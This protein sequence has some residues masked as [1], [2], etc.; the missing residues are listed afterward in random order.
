MAIFCVSFAPDSFSKTQVIQIDCPDV[1]EVMQ[2]LQR[3]FPGTFDGMLIT[4]IVEFRPPDAQQSVAAIPRLLRERYG[5]EGYA[6]GCAA[7]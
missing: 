5:A 3:R 2:Y 4:A 7:G 1:T 6:A